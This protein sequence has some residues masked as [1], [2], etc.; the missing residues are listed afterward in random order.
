MCNIFH[1][2]NLN[3]KH[4][5]T[6]FDSHLKFLSFMQ[7][8]SLKCNQHSTGYIP[9]CFLP[10]WVY[11]YSLRLIKSGPPGP[12]A[13]H[14]LQGCGETPHYLMRWSWVNLRA[15]RLNKGKELWNWWDSNHASKVGNTSLNQC[16]Q[17]N[18]EIPLIVNFR[19]ILFTLIS[20]TN[21]FACSVTR[22]GV[23]QRNY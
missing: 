3:L 9:L 13:L 20:K 19:F 4:V 8:S 23:D 12:M 14:P 5:H 7:I 6:L 17:F 11:H 1:F 16:P 22:H 21:T 15:L 2:Q 10:F 18:H